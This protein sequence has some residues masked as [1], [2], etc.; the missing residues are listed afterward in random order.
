MDWA[1]LDCNCLDHPARELDW[2]GTGLDWTGLDW[3]RP[4]MGWTALECTRLDWTGWDWDRTWLEG[5]GLD[6]I[7]SHPDTLEGTQET[8]RR[9]EAPRRYPGG[10]Q[11]HQG[12]GGLGGICRSDLMKHHS[13]SNG[14]HQIL[15]NL[16]F[17]TVLWCYHI[18]TAATTR[19]QGACIHLGTKVSLPASRETHQL[20]LA[21]RTNRMSASNLFLA[22]LLH[23]S[24]SMILC[25][26]EAQTH[27]LPTMAVIRVWSSVVHSS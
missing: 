4:G 7:W 6:W 13:L 16:N 26:I 15:P 20:K 2:T 21:W 10:T 3:T 17:T 18:I 12:P 5:T 22:S 27:K 1:R 23:N 11:M 9:Q 19:P 25:R 24:S 8:L 14:M